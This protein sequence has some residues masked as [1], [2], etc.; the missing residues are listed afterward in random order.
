M[1]SYLTSEVGWDWLREDRRFCSKHSCSQS[2]VQWGWPRSCCQDDV[3]QA[4]Q[5]C[6][7]GNSDVPWAPATKNTFSHQQEHSLEL[8]GSCRFRFSIDH[9][10]PGHMVNDPNPDRL[11]H[12]TTLGI[13]RERKW[14]LH[15][16]RR[17]LATSFPSLDLHGPSTVKRQVECHS[18][19]ISMALSL[20][21]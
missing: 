4:G 9:C 8:P 20:G 7:Y 21:F 17:V 10:R 16:H 1:L 13:V 3:R 15:L 19:S 2:S 11:E 14:G 5:S 12:Y 6:W 18:L